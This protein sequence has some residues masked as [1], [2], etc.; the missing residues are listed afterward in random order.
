MR[1]LELRISCEAKRIPIAK[2]FMC[3]CA[4]CERSFTYNSNVIIVLRFTIIDRLTR[5]VLDLLLLL[6]SIPSPVYHLV[7]GWFPVIFLCGIFSHIQIQL[8]KKDSQEHSYHW[9][10]NCIGS[11]SIIVRLPNHS[12]DPIALPYKTYFHCAT[13]A[14]TWKYI[15]G[16]NIFASYN[17]RLRAYGYFLFHFS[18]DYF[19]NL[20][21]SKSKFLIVLIFSRFYSCANFERA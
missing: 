14:Y 19:S 4:D 17:G 21:R 13:V 11:C 7:F 16:L 15:K 18:F 8:L 12:P 1:K 9:T 20:F 6:D 3:L 5:Q 10:S 2:C